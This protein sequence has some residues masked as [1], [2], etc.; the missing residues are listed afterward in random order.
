MFIVY[1]SSR[2]RDKA[3]HREARDLDDLTVEYSSALKEVN[4]RLI[5]TLYKTYQEK[6][7]IPS[8]G[9]LVEM[10]DHRQLNQEDEYDRNSS[11]DNY[12]HRSSRR[13]DGNRRHGHHRSVDRSRKQ[14]VT[15]WEEAPPVSEQMNL[16]PR[17]PHVFDLNTALGP[18]R[19]LRHPQV[20]SS[21]QI[22]DPW[23]STDSTDAPRGSKLPGKDKNEGA[24][25]ARR[26]HEEDFEAENAYYNASNENV[27]NT[28]Q[29]PAAGWKTS[30]VAAAREIPTGHM[31]PAS[32]PSRTIIDRS[33]QQGWVDEGVRSVSNDENSGSES[34]SRKK[35]GGIKRVVSRSEFASSVTQPVL[36]TLSVRS[37]NVNADSAP[38]AA[39][40]EEKSSA[41]NRYTPDM[42]GP[43][44]SASINVA[45]D[46]WSGAPLHNNTER[47]LASTARPAQPSAVLQSTGDMSAATAM[48]VDSLNPRM[49]QVHT[50]NMQ[51]RIAARDS[52]RSSE[53]FHHHDRSY[54]ESGTKEIEADFSR[55]NESYENIDMSSFVQPS[56]NN[57]LSY[58]GERDLRGI[59]QRDESS[60]SVE[61]YIASDLREAEREQQLHHQRLLQ[62]QEQDQQRSLQHTLNSTNDSVMVEEFDDSLHMDHRPISG[63]TS[64][65]PDPLPAKQQVR[66][67]GSVTPGRA[68]LLPPS[69]SKSTPKRPERD[70]VF[71]PGEYEYSMSHDSPFPDL[72]GGK[73]FHHQ[74]GRNNQSHISSNASNSRNY[75]DRSG[76]SHHTGGSDSYELDAFE[77]EEDDPFGGRASS[78]PKRTLDLTN[79]TG[80][81]TDID[82]SKSITID[83]V[84]PSE[85]KDLHRHASVRASEGAKSQH[86]GRSYPYEEPDISGELD[87]FSPLGGPQGN[88]GR[89]G[90]TL[91]AG[92]RGALRDD[93]DDVLMGTTKLSSGTRDFGNFSNT[94]QSRGTASD[95][96]EQDSLGGTF[97]SNPSTTGNKGT[98]FSPMTAPTGGAEEEEEEESIPPPT[99]DSMIGTGN[100]EDSNASRS[101]LQ[102]SQDEVS[103]YF[104]V[105]ADAPS[106]HVPHHLHMHAVQTEAEAAGTVA[107]TWK[108]GRAPVDAIELATAFDMFVSAVQLD[109]QHTRIYSE[110]RLVLFLLVPYFLVSPTRFC[111]LFSSV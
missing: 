64:S 45:R 23:A 90:S 57:S 76:M 35:A 103:S 79:I 7:R 31:V 60:I 66:V 70:E 91:G 88:A 15:E 4:P 38:A 78:G 33:Q 25:W 77:D 74:Q 58:T 85:S 40:P 39:R 59:S 20:G 97:N 99:Y 42:S 36:R 65:D 19:T 92:P 87:L 52:S 6:V 3:L 73:H 111:F 53:R 9:Q 14:G 10:A 50:P 67:S 100:T 13:G 94:F 43:R 83:F 32:L 63:F 110:V 89:F 34:D 5:N 51:D 86:G 82:A 55:N 56:N 48:S 54:E 72:S 2:A 107:P 105:S 62:E 8:T 37:I 68:P 49:T 1:V 47:Q 27:S 17:E 106:A 41:N 102:Q 16:Q 12:R 98:T 29:P 75:N 109:S 71:S 84:L 24:G 81:S 18:R 61:D 44:P 21:R 26:R 104:E 11:D 108:L 95:R 101:Q 22:G 46:G 28:A 69:A 30:T 96:F 93:D 80:G